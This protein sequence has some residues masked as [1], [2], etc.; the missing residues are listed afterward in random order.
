MVPGVAILAHT[1]TPLAGAIEV[2]HQVAGHDEVAAGYAGCTAIHELAR[3]HEGGCF[4]EL[5]HTFAHGTRSNA[6]QSFQRERDMLEILIVVPPTERG[7]FGGGSRCASGVSR[8]PRVRLPRYQ[9][10]VLSA[11]GVGAE[12]SPHAPQPTLRHRRLSTE[13]ASVPI[14]PDA[15]A[16]G[17]A[18][19]ITR[20]VELPRTFARLEQCLDVAQ[21]PRRKAEQ[22][23][24]FGRLLH[25]N[26]STR[27]VGR[28]GPVA[29]VD[30]V[31]RPLHCLHR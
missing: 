6:R 27:R 26:R 23:L 3:H 4:V 31:A 22:F 28:A 21:P 19:L 20:N 18:A 1:M 30:T 5:L 16:C 17:T 9:P 11:I 10:S 2:A 24:R 25:G 13:S 12:Q 8:Q 29:T 14:E 15:N 7:G